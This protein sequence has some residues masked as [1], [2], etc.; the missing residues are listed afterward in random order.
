MKYTKDG[1]LPTESEDRQ[2]YMLGGI[3]YMYQDDTFTSEAT[4]V[5]HLVHGWP[6]QAHNVTKAYFNATATLALWL[7]AMFHKSFPDFYWKYKK[8]GLDEEPAVIFSMECFEGGECY[9]PNLKLKLVYHPGE[10]I[11][12]M[13]GALYHS[14]GERMPGLECQRMG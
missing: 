7:G 10:V 3:E 2:S 1:G 14:I 13:A 12:L 9:L 8:D 11:I 5:L 6:D 4:S